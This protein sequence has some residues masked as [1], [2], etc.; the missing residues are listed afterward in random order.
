MTYQRNL[1]LRAAV[2]AA[3][4]LSGVA[5][6]AGVGSALPAKIATAAIKDDTTAVTG[7]A[8]A[9]S[10]QVPLSN[11]TIYYIYV[12]MSPGQFSATPVAA[13]VLNSN[14]ATLSRAITGAGTVSKLSTDKTFA[15][16]T[17]SAT[18]AVVP[19]NTTISFTPKS[20]ASKGQLN[21]LSSLLAG[22]NVNAQISIGSS[23]STSAV[24]ADIDSASGGNIITFTAAQTATITSSGSFAGLA[25][26]FNGGANGVAETKQINV[27]GGTGVSMTPAGAGSNTATASLIDF[28]A[29]RFKNV[30]G[31]LTADNIN[32][33]GSTW[34]LT[35]AYTGT[36]VGAT[37]TGNFAAAATA[38]MYVSSVATCASSIGQLAVNTAKTIAAVGSGSLALPATNTFS[39]AVCMQTDGKTVIPATQPT[40]LVSL[41]PNAGFSARGM[42][43]VISFPAAGAASL[44]S[45]VTNGGLVDVRS[46]IP[47]ATVGYTT[48]LRVINTGQVAATISAAFID[49]VTG[50]VG[51]AAALPGGPLAAGGASNY[52][53]AQIETALGVTQAASARPR[54][55]VT[56]PTTISVQH[57]IVNPNA[58]LTTLHG[59]D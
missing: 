36:P 26:T 20:T 8:V 49:P 22:G 42:G 28:G 32:A 59:S 24:L 51:T 54:L 5:A 34:T 6:H 31:V 53:A 21:T 52:S 19:V 1:I 48:V 4:G 44:Y 40:L 57:Y 37:V 30:A 2:A 10:T 29:Y 45:L 16:Y 38:G 14:N 58:T 11:N 18:T 43:S 35:N 46:Y 56:A 12:K 27:A 13:S 7:N 15:V 25:Q 9:Y 23:S 55:R 39:S 17:L 33:A 3:F 47:A 41:K 50:V